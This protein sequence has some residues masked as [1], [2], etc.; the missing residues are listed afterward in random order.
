MGHKLQWYKFILKFLYPHC[1]HQH[2]NLI[3]TVF[4]MTYTV[5]SGTLN[6]TIPYHTIPYHLI[7]SCWWSHILPLQK[8]SSTTFWVILLIDRQ[9]D[10]QT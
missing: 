3:S 1:D 2:H 7:S 6:S 4:K 5:S 8:I 9:T 10:R